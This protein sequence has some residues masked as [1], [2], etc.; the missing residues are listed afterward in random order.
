M[1]V[2]HPHTLLP[3]GAP[4][5]CKLLPSTHF[6]TTIPRGTVAVCWRVE[7]KYNN[8]KLLFL[9]IIE[10]QLILE[11][12]QRSREI[13][14][15]FWEQGEGKLALLSFLKHLKLALMVRTHIDLHSKW[16]YCIL[17]NVNM[18]VIHSIYFLIIW[19]FFVYTSPSLLN[20]CCSGFWGR[21]P[22][23]LG[24]RW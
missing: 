9:K 11:I 1:K 7:V 4:V 3:S 12:W 20:S 18:D 23:S 22:G 15:V 24:L 21:I 10:S 19:F 5:T 13:V 8:R 6:L 14:E 2:S 17:K 16:F